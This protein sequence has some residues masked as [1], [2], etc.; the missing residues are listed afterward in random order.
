MR[1]YCLSPFHCS[2]TR[3]AIFIATFS[4]CDFPN[5]A[6]PPYY[7]CAAVQAEH[8]TMHLLTAAPSIHQQKEA[9]REG[10][11]EAEALG[12]LTPEVT[13]VVA[14]ADLDISPATAPTKTTL[15]VIKHKESTPPLL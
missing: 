9:G 12:V 2:C 15:K 6:P 8:P 3:T 14:E 11:A 4:I 1:N 10:L 7:C 5:P 13:L